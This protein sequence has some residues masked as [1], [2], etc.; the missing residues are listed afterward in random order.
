MAERKKKSE[1][2]KYPVEDKIILIINAPTISDR[3]K[4][5]AIIL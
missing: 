1:F 5:I 3:I 2:S 4:S